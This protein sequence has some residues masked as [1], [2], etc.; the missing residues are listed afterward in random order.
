MH[1]ICEH[2]VL[3]FQGMK[4]GS[5]CT[6]PEIYMFGVL[7]CGGSDNGHIEMC[8][9]VQEVKYGTPSTPAL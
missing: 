1:T 2:P 6:Y 7:G 8:G 5:G 3:A 4:K 9:L